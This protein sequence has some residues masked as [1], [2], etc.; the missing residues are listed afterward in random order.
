MFI[1][2]MLIFYIEAN[3][4]N[5]DTFVPNVEEFAEKVTKSKMTKRKK[6]EIEV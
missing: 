4:G 5:V 1:M 6:K 2:G 3:K